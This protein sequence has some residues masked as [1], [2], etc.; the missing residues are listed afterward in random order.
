MLPEI[1]QLEFNTQNETYPLDPGKSFLF[2]FRAGEFGLANGKLIPVEGTA[3]IKIWIEKILRTDK[4]R[5]KI[6]AKSNGEDE[7]GVMLEDLVVGYNYPTAF[8]EAELKREISTAL[9]KH[10]Q[11]EFLS[12][13]MIIKNA[14]YLQVIFR[15]N[16]KDGSSFE[17]EVNI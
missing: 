8:L 5:F 1:A 12:N 14:P 15:V 4:Y 7:Y 16:L 17:Q 2:D 3:A 11:I 6:Y 10:P 13:W 9:L